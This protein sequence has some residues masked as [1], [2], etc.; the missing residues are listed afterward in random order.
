MAIEKTLGIIKPDAVRNNYVGKI[1]A[2][3]TDAG[4]RVAAL[5]MKGMSLA[6]A[7]AFYDI[8]EGK[9]FFE[10]LI[11]F[12]TE[13]PCVVMVLEKEGAVAGWRELM[14]ATNP[15]EA[16]EGTLRKIF[17][18]SFTRNAVHG[19]DS[20]ENAKREIEFFFPASEVF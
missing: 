4:F 6:T 11:A 15:A 8:H 17:A 14:G 18:E 16:A 10:D 19:S 7:K 13:G 20:P 9:P 2:A 5:S 12:M 3:A 1:L